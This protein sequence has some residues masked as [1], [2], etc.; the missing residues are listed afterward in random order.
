MLHV[1]VI[2]P[3]GPCSGAKR[4]LRAVRSGR[5]DEDPPVPGRTLTMAAEEL[6]RLKRAA[7][8][9]D[10]DTVFCIGRLESLLYE[11]GNF[12]HPAFLTILYA[13]PPMPLHRS[14]SARRAASVR[15]RVANTLGGVAIG[16]IDDGIAFAH[17]RFRDR[18]GGTRVEAIWLQD[19]RSADGGP[20]LDKAAIDGLIARHRRDA[21]IYR[22]VGLLDFR[23]G[24]HKPLAFGTAHGTHCLDLLAGA[25]PAA[26][27]TDR[28][29]FAVQLPPELVAD[30]SAVASGGH[31]LQGLQR[32]FG[33][34]DRHDP[35]MP[36]VVNFSYGILAGPK[37]GSHPLEKAVDALIA[38]RRRRAP[39]FLM[40]PAGNGDAQR[41]A[42]AVDLPPRATESLDWIIPP[43]DGTPNFIEIWTANGP[44][45]RSPLD[46]ALLSPGGERILRAPVKSGEAQVASGDGGIVGQALC[47]RF[48]RDGAT[49]FRQ[50]FA[51]AAPRSPLAGRASRIMPGRW[52]LKLRNS[53]DE[54]LRIWV[55]V[56]RDG[57]PAGYPRRGRQGSIDH[58][59]LCARD[60]ATGDWTA[61]AAGSRV[62][63]EGSL[64]AIATGAN[65]IVV[66]AA[67]GIDNLWPTDY[68]GSGPVEGRMGPDCAALADAGAA[69]RGVMAAGALSGTV[70]PMNGT[71]VAAPQA[72]RLLADSLSIARTGRAG[73]AFPDGPEIPADRVVAPTADP[74]RLGW[75]VVKPAAADRRR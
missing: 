71:S 7:S 67:E 12:R 56:Q 55:G 37:D 64:S 34:V 13:G 24:A 61:A 58:P 29:I 49:R 70:R 14:P 26:A 16:I 18:D 48:E 45:E 51:L 50:F 17:E 5:F 15:R 35:R 1:G 36:L 8:D 59:D 23:E 47:D 39:T 9:P 20:V 31:V 60:P 41:A 30:T 6:E 3:A 54:Q 42:V 4:L 62:R 69:R 32:I 2:D 63:F 21:D 53:G 27:P 22:E 73:L 66:G 46:V 75:F 28:P 43:D 52:V 40:L 72:G 33:W 74:T 57:T 68:T 44:Q 25:D 11:A 65:T 38:D 19:E 10:G